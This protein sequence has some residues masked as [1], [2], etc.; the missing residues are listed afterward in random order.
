VGM[1]QYAKQ[2]VGPSSKMFTAAKHS[3]RNARGHQGGA[4]RYELG[5]GDMRAKTTEA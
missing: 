2:Q 4:A 3:C 5:E 1:G